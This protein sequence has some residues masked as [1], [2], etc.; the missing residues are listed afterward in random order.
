M[1]F[2]PVK[3][4]FLPLK[5]FHFLNY[6]QLVE[7]YVRLETNSHFKKKALLTTRHFHEDW[8][9]SKTH[10]HRFFTALADSGLTLAKA[11][12]KQV[13]TLFLLTAENPLWQM[14]RKGIKFP[15][16]VPHN[17]DI[18]GASTEQYAL[19][20]VAKSVSSGE[21]YPHL[22]EVSSE[23]LIPISTFSTI[24]RGLLLEKHGA[25]LLGI[26]G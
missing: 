15:D 21:R 5:D 6:R 8:F 16:F 12:N 23:S 7:D 22:A 4:E 24:L 17:K 20:Q 3:Q 2:H 25:I 11:K 26:K 18:E 14:V 19:F 9:V 13:A 1:P 10:R